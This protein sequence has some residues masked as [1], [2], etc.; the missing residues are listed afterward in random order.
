M[1]ST[2]RVR[3]RCAGLRHERLPDIVLGNRGGSTCDPEFTRRI[4]DFMSDLGY[5]VTINSPYQ[6]AEIIRRHGNPMLGRHSL[7]IEINRDLYMDED[8]FKV[9]RKPFNILK[10]NLM[11]LTVDLIEHYGRGQSDNESLP[12]AAE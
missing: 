9:K 3:T 5:E 11:L 2:Y 7:Q 8:S 6:G 4:A 12:L 10:K 1:P